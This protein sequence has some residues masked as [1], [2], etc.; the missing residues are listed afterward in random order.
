MRGVGHD[1]HVERVRADRDQIRALAGCKRTNLVAHPHGARALDGAE[2]ECLARR[3]LEFALGLGVLAVARKL[4][5]SEQ[6]RGSDQRRGVDRD[7][8]R[9]ALGQH[10][11]D[12]RIAVADAQFRA[13]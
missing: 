2:L 3:Q 11:A 9:N 6:V 4:E 1:R 13:G 7:T 12:L 10:L 8:E 5:H